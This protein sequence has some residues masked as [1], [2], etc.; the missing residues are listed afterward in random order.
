MNLF[1]KHPKEITPSELDYWEKESFMM[2]IPKNAEDILNLDLI[3]KR[4]EE[5]KSFKLTSYDFK[6][7]EGLLELKISYEKEEYVANMFLSDF[8]FDASYIGTSF[9][10]PDEEITSLKNAHFCLTMSM[11]FNENPFKSFHL[12]L[13]IATTVV[14]DFISLIDESAE[15]ILPYKWVSL[16]GASH[17]L[18]SVGDLYN[19]QIVYNKK[20]EMWLHTHGLCRCGFSELEI[21][22]S[23][24]DIVKYHLDVLNAYASLYIEHGPNFNLYK[25]SLEVGMLPNGKIITIISKPWYEA[26]KDYDKLSI[27]N[28]ADRQNSHNSKRSVLFLEEDDDKHIIKLSDKKDLFK[29]EPVFFISN[30][31]TAKM[32]ALAQERFIYLKKAFKTQNKKILVKLGLPLDYNKEEKEYIW[33]EVTKIVGDNITTVLTQEPYNV[34]SMHKNDIYVAS[35]EQI[36]DF[37]IFTPKYK[38][39][40]NTVYLLEEELKLKTL[41]YG[42]ISID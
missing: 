33:F 25:E 2:I 13:K 36:V 19:T 24:Q 40:P 39:T 32:R 14:P 30:E 41:D 18:P 17:V 16:T 11:K 26:L 3:I 35:K 31:E 28:L 42:L 37:I 15:R 7:K 22:K 23:N 5:A 10:V 9:Y 27:G 38:I 8:Q 29:E 12:Q 6:E 1:K 4:L 20:G 34:S 21:L